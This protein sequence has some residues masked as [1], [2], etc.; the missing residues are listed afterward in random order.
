MKNL[1]KEKE[2][3]KEI[4][5]LNRIFKE[6]DKDRKD[7]SKGLIEESAFMKLTL[8]ELKILIDE[9]GPI[10]EMPQGDYSI[11]REHPALKSYISMINRYTSVSKELFNLLPK[12]VQKEGDDGFDAFLMKR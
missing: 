7:A 11:L 3:K 6:V 9:N 2:I 8:I 5:R 1:D 10:D 12:E 4:R